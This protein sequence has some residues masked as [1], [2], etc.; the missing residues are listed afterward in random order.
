MDPI[1]ITTLLPELRN[2]FS[3]DL[4]GRKECLLDVR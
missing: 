1:T 4:F 2:D 3:S